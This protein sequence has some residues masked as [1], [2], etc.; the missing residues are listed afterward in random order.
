[1]SPRLTA[2]WRR[3]FSSVRDARN[4]RLYLTGHI[5]SAVG[6]WMNFTAASWL[7]L[8]LSDGSGTAL[9]ANA[10]LMFGPMLLLGPWGGV[11]AD[12]HDKRRILMLTQSL[13]ALLAVTMAIIV[14]TDI[15][16]LELVY[17]MSVLTGLV[18]AIDNP[19]R[20]SFVVEMVGE[21]A[22]T[23]AV[24]LN[25]AAFMLAR[26]VGPA[27]AGLLI[28]S[29]GLAICFAVDAVSYIAVLTAL[30]AMRPE[31]MHAQERTTRDSGHLMAGFRY[32]WRT[33]DL[34]RPLLL[35]A[36]I[37][38]LCFQWQVLV[39]L[40]AE[41]TFRAGPAEFGALSAAAGVG[42][43]LGAITMA[44]RDPRP[45]MRLLAG[46]A[47]F[48]GVAL[49]VIA[50][51]PSLWAA[52]LLMIPAGFGSMAFMITGNTKLQLASVPQARGR[53][54]ALY[55]VIFL[56]STPIG[57]PIVGWIGE[58]LGPRAGYVIT[59]TIAVL[60]GGVVLAL[61]RRAVRAEATPVATA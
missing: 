30:W 44:N 50:F 37:F 48:V 18:I 60:A 45:G 28:A 6:T 20:Q 34:R 26:V 13:F 31:E 29:V 51:A 36:V 1:V 54:M 59:G 17:V 12:K 4:F 8:R 2:A 39:P 11:L 42:A 27:V 14:A 49:V 43:F 35:M 56:G 5:I 21:D 53:V 33:D 32:V 25:S 46:I 41:L 40:L 22:I 19:A 10:A 52:A 3:T 7:V 57:S 61:A 15:V 16:T 38:T 23:N 47:M 24:S 58:H 9:G 55:G